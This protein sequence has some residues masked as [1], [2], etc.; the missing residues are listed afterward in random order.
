MTRLSSRNI[1]LIGFILV[2]LGFV[3]PLLIVLKILE[4]TFAL[5]FFSFAASMAGLLLGL[6]GAAQHAVENRHKRNE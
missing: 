3:L 2:L 6:V 5:N 1:L 4:S